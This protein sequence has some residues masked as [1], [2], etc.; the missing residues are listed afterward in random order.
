MFQDLLKTRLTSLLDRRRGV[1]IVDTSV[2][3]YYWNGS[4]PLPHRVRDI[5]RTGIFLFTEERWYPG[6]MLQLTLDFKTGTAITPAA[7]A[8]VESTRVWSKVVWF[9]ADGVGFEFMQ[10][11]AAERKKMADLIERATGV[12][13]KNDAQSD[14]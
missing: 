6:T 10:V 2:V 1:R 12:G 3:A 11:K 13:E 5:S 7:A 4:V 9:E 14:K 8:P